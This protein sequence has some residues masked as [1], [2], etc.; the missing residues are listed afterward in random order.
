MFDLIRQSFYLVVHISRDELIEDA[1]NILVNAGKDLKKPLKV[2]FKGEPGIDEGGVQK[3][4]FQLLIREIFDIGYGMFD[5]NE[6]SN[7]YWFK[8]D[9]FESPIKFELIGIIL[10][11]AI[12]NGNILD[13]HF[14]MALYKKLLNRDL[15]LEDLTQYDPQ[16]ANS[17]KAILNYE[18][19]DF[20]EAMGLTFTLEYESWGANVEEE[21]KH[22]GKNIPVTLE[23][24]E[25][26]VE[27]Y[28]NFLMS[29]SI[30]KWFD[31]FKKGFYK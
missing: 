14:P 7:L 26:Y 5:Y 2:K 29:T 28:V 22:D 27:L 1:L 4:F 17:L 19:E 13:V 3:E 20:T 31:S 16:V 6:Q 21:L 8:K 23:N 18:N 11:L 9:T 15:S 10:G 25:E 12:Y 24:R 30:S